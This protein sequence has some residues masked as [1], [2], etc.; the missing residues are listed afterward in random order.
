MQDKILSILSY[1]DVFDHPMHEH[2]LKI[3]SDNEAIDPVLKKLLGSG[4]V[5]NHGQYFS[6]Q[7]NV[8]ELVNNRARKEIVARNYFDKLPNQSYP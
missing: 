5:Y 3:L 6:L 4:L 2:E 7:S 8:E 1:F